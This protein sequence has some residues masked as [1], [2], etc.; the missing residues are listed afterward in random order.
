MVSLEGDYRKWLTLD[1]RKLIRHKG[2]PLRTFK[3]HISWLPFNF[4][5]LSSKRL[6]IWFYLL[7]CWFFFLFVARNKVSRGKIVVFFGDEGK[8]LMEID[9]LKL[10]R[11]GRKMSMGFSREVWAG[12]DWNLVWRKMFGV[13]WMELRF[14][15]EVWNNG[16]NRIERCQG[17]CYWKLIQCN[18]ISESILCFQI[19]SSIKIKANEIK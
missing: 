16:K 10:G 13:F 2:F 14:F 9:R 4:D 19:G 17:K 8:R 1:E 15:S 3:L 18:S 5:G 11:R 7:R 12:K 6:S